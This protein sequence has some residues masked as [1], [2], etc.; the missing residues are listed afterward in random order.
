MK[1][2]TGRRIKSETFLNDGDGKELS[3]DGEEQAGT[4]AKHHPGASIET[5]NV[6][7]RIAG[8][9]QFV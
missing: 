5:G 6:T 2:S 7:F 9:C 3:G 8:C 4:A 1:F